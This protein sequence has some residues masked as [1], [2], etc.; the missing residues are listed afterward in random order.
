LCRYASALLNVAAG[1]RRHLHLPDT[2]LAAEARAALHASLDDARTKVKQ[3]G[4]VL[5][6]RGSAALH[7]LE[8]AAAEAARETVG[9]LV[10]LSRL[11]Q[12]DP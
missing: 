3:A 8:D 7:G 10:G 12:V 9:L 11:N 6:R 5:A 2:P 1:L 4:A